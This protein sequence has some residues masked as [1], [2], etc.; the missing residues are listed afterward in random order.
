MQSLGKT[1]FLAT[2][3]TLLALAGCT[4]TQHAASTICTVDK[5]TPL[6]NMTLVEWTPSPPFT[7]GSG[8]AAWIQVTK[9]PTSSGGLF[10]T[11]GAIAEV[12]SI[13]SGT[14]PNV[15]TGSNGD[16]QSQDPAIVIQKALTWQK[17]SLAD[18]DWQL[19]SASNPGIEVVSCPG[20][21]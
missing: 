1:R 18:G 20:S 11:M 10:G 8:S 17:L 5:R 14:A 21:S 6:L 4:S 16:R 13:P 9:D 2:T 3:L 12:H 19:Y 7:V 15:V